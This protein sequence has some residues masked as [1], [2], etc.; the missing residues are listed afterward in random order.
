MFSGMAKG[1]MPQ[2]MRQAN[3][4]GEFFIAAQATSQRTTELGYFQR[5]RQAGTVMI[6]CTAAPGTM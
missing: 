6:A 4:F 3:R 2:I 5:M 1:R